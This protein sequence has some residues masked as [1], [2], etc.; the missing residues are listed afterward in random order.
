MHELM[1]Q[2]FALHNFDVTKEE[3]II[4]WAEEEAYEVF[5][6]IKKENE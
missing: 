4:T 2:S 3:E 1:H 6:L 5:K